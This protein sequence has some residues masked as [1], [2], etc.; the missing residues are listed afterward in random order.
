VTAV[1]TTAGAIGASGLRSAYGAFP[2]G[3]AAVC[4]V[5]DDVPV[6]FAMSS[7]VAVSLDPPLVS[8]CVQHTST[9]WPLLVDRPRLGLS[10]LGRGQSAVCRRLASKTE[11]RFKDVAV[12]TTDS[13]AVLID[14][15]AAWF[16]CSLHDV[17]RA[18]DHDL[19]LMRVER[20]LVHGD[21]E[22]LV[23]HGSTFRD[24]AAAIA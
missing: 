3:V 14:G 15:A 22:P 7:F 5:R 18:G 23:F 10:V 8:V 6:G 1:L 13:G 20:L 21:V 4:A 16:E 12:T 9:T 2:S 24:L 17:V 11:D 19:V